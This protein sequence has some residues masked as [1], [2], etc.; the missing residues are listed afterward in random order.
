MRGQLRGLKDT[1]QFTP[2]REGRPY[3]AI[4]MQTLIKQFQ[5]TPLRE[6]RPCNA[7]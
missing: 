7:A 1:F 5:F 2:L 3:T 4:G 6:G